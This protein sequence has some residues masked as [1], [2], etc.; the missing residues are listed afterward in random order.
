M[1]LPRFST[2]RPYDR[3][4]IVNVPTTHRPAIISELKHLT[5]AKSRGKH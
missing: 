1:A 5:G 3:V 4:L 2:V